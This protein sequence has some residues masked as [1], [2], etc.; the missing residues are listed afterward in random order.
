MFLFC[1]LFYFFLK[2][3]HYHCLF[4]LVLS[5]LAFLWGEILLELGVDWEDWGDE[6]AWGTKS[7]RINEKRIS[8]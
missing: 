6:W 3:N 5:F 4:I 7:Q 2:K 1:F 8:Y